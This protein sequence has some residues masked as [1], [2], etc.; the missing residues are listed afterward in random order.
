MKKELLETSP[1][2]QEINQSDLPEDN[3]SNTI[4]LSDQSK[5]TGGITI[6]VYP[7]NEGISLVTS[8]NILTTNMATFSSHVPVILTEGDAEESHSHCGI[9]DHFQV[10]TTTSV[11]SQS[12]STGALD[13]MATSAD[14]GRSVMLSEQQQ[15]LL[16]GMLVPAVAS[17]QAVPIKVTKD[18]ATCMDVDES[19]QEDEVMW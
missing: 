2:T 9:T 16:S 19:Q 12:D 11:L 14:F 1:K 10:V 13:A 6:D 17:G 4:L 3:L 15:V 8:N 5:N 7:Q 18:V